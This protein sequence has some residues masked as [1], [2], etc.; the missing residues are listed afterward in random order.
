MRIK[1]PAETD[2]KKLV[3]AAAEQLGEK[4]VY[5]G[6]P[7]LNYILG[8]YTVA[9][10]RTLAGP[11][12]RD[13]VAALR[14]LGYEPEDET[15]DTEPA[16]PEADETAQ[17]DRLTIE[18]S[19]D[20]SFTPAK[21]ANLEKLIASRETLLKKVLGANAL[22]IEQGD[23]VLRFPWFPADENA[24]VYNQLASALIRVAT[25]ATRITAREQQDCASEKFRMRTY[26]LKLGFIADRTSNRFKRR[27]RLKMKRRASAG[28]AAWPE[29]SACHDNPQAGSHKSACRTVILRRTSGSWGSGSR[30]CHS[31]IYFSSPR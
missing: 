28:W 9:C 13:L 21:M 19:V 2:R 22:P 8:A 30:D 31:L 18:V 3:V 26:L 10:D 7:T 24:M 15:Y 20:D 25:E 11:D 16:V 4:P 14:E 29:H 23:G 6:A 1:Y 17:P 12:N 27:S 5:A